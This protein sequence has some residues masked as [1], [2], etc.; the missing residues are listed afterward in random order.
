MPD[1][2]H[3]R[4]V[5]PKNRNLSG[6]LYVELDGKPVTRMRVL[7]RGSRGPGDTQF[8]ENG[9]TPTGV[10]DGSVFQS[11]Q[12]FPV[13]SYGPWGA[14]RL[15]PLSGNAITAEKLFGRSGL[16]IHGGSLGGPGYWRGN[17]ALRATYGC[18][19]VSNSD[20]HTLLQLLVEDDSMGMS[21][22]TLPAVT[23]TIQD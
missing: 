17:G 14:I 5:V 8:L 1:R 11:T 23:V 2:V 12:N 13:E 15:K 22:A 3:L 16:L 9:N 6:W 18:L 10:Y 21:R 7:A 4:V 19:R 20:M